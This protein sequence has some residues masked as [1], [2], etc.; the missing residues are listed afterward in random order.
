MAGVITFIVQA[1]RGKIV[2]DLSTSIEFGIYLS[3]NILN[4]FCDGAEAG[5]LWATILP[6]P[7]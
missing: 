3:Q 6:N 7:M 4:S 1:L 5:A 2:A